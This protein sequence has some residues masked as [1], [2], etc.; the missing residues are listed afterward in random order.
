MMVPHSGL[1][2]RVLAALDSSPARIAVVIGGCGTGRTT[3]LHGLTDRLGRDQC[4]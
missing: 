4:Q 2:R 1:E 3:L